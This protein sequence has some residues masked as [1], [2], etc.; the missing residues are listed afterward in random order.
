MIDRDERLEW[1]FAQQC[2]HPVDHLIL[3]FLAAQR[4]L[5]NRYIV[6]V[7]ELA[8]ILNLSPVTLVRSLYR[9]DEAGLISVNRHKAGLVTLS[10]S[11]WERV[12]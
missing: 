2:D 9:M 8:P 3:V 7:D 11:V 6:H 1:A 4:P 12:P 10:L 5:P